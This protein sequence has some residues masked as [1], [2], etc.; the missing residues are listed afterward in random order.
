MTQAGHP[1]CRVGDNMERTPGGQKDLAGGDEGQN[2]G[3][4]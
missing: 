2:R 1:V 4:G 3:D